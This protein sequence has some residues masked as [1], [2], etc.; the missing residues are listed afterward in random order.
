MKETRIDITCKH[1]N[2]KYSILA[3]EKKKSDLR[4]HVSNFCS[5][6]CYT[7]HRKENPQ[8]KKSKK[9]LACQTQ[10][11]NK[12]CSTTCYHQYRSKLRQSEDYSGKFFVAKKYVLER[13]NRACQ[14]CGIKTYRLNVHH[15]DINPENQKISNLITLC[16][17]CHSYVHVLKEPVQKV[18]QTYM[19][20]VA[21]IT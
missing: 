1:C 20:S 5:R 13:D 21:K 19:E 17:R 3:S 8:M 16:S 18:L 11:K 14:L 2:K 7:L 9:C 15:I 10:T 4:G 6:N 12:F